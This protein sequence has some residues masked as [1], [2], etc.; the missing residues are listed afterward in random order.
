VGAKVSGEKEQKNKIESL[1]ASAKF[2][3]AGLLY[4]LPCIGLSAT[5]RAFLH[6][7]PRPDGK[8]NDR[9]GNPMSD[10]GHD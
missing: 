6:G 5:I 4:G 8:A 9:G 7:E 10:I 1:D 2:A 3:A